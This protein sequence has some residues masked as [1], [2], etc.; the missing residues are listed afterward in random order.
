MRSSGGGGCQTL[1][2]K[3]QFRLF[4]FLFFPFWRKLPRKYLQEEEE[5]EKK[6]V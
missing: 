3:V 1:V 5:E 2:E 6:V 4:F